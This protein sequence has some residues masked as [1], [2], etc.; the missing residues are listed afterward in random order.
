MYMEWGV[1][2]VLV[3]AIGVLRLLPVLNG[4][5]RLAERYPCRFPVRGEEFGFA[6]AMMRGLFGMYVYVCVARGGV[7]IDVWWLRVW[8]PPVFLPWSD[9]IH[10][11]QSGLFGGDATLVCR[12]A[13]NVP[14]RLI[15]RAALAEWERYG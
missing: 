12:G 15:G 3:L 8:H 4:W 2:W 1:M 6:R 9:V 5:E 14:I 13:E 7:M 10:C 11:E